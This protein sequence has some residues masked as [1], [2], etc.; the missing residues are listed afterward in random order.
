MDPSVFPS[1]EIFD[2]DRWTTAANDGVNLTKYLV[3]FTK[4]SRGCL[5]ISMAYAEMYLTVARI[6]R[7]FEMELYETTESDVEAYHIRLTGYPRKGKGEVKVK[8]SARI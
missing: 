2:P 4:G 6:I 1:P 8:I 7:R 3:S 5:G